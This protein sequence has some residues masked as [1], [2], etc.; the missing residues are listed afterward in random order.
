MNIFFPLDGQQASPTEASRIV[1][2]VD[3]N[4]SPLAKCLADK[5]AE[6]ICE[7]EEPYQTNLIDWISKCAGCEIIDLNGDLAIMMERFDFLMLEQFTI[8]EIFCNEVALHLGREGKKR[9]GQ[10]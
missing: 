3:G 4:V 9:Q 2:E 7:V 10:K 6:I 1:G 8:M 5:L